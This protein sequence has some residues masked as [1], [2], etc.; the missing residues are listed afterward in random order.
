M[1]K[2]N[3]LVT[4]ALSTLGL[5]ISRKLYE[6]GYHVYG[7]ARD[8]SRSFPYGR[9]LELDL[10]KDDY[11][12]LDCIESLSLLV[13]NAGVF[14]VGEQEGLSDDL[15]DSVVDINIRGLFKVTRKV[16]PFL[17]HSDGAIVNISSIN[18]FHP[19]FG[20]TVHYDASKGFVS[21]YT[22]SLAAE[23]G[24]RVNAVAPGLIEA[25]RLK[26]SEIEK[27]FTSRAILRKMVAPED[28]AELVLFLSHAKGIYGETIVLDN[29]YLKG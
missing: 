1:E 4:G 3:A 25:D 20:G 5:A 22:R 19:G 18:A 14:T 16:L 28:V 17:K 10:V 29:G 6:N 11:S 21:S 27:V 13:N 7:T 12:S 15:F 2:A 24:L 9:L 23:T 8:T 26:G